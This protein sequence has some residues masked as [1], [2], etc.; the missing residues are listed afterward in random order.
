M[1]S[2][3]PTRDS[4]LR[5]WTSVPQIVVVV[6]RITA[7]PGPACGRVTSSTRMSPGAWN[8][9]ARM[10]PVGSDAGS[11][12]ARAVMTT[13]RSCAV[14]M[15]TGGGRRWG[16]GSCRHLRSRGP[17]GDDQGG[18]DREIDDQRE[19]HAGHRKPVPEDDDAGQGDDRRD[20]R[21]GAPPGGVREIAR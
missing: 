6:I 3:R 8:T 15:T 20:D 16:N 5:M 10:V 17:V 18:Q 19:H 12:V 9:V 13:R 14:K 21:R 1:T 2:P 11:R 7:S 4:T